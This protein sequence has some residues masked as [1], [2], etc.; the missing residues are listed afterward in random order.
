MVG[1]YNEVLAEDIE[2]LEALVSEAVDGQ[3]RSPLTID[4]PGLTE[5]VQVSGREQVAYMVDMA[6]ADALDLLGE[7]R[8]A[9][10]LV[11]RHV[12]RSGYLE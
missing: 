7:S 5:N 6:K 2:R 4:L 1:I 3:N 11:D 8:Q 10:E 12:S 9:F